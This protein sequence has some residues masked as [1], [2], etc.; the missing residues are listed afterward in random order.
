MPADVSS[1]GPPLYVSL[2][3][4]ATAHTS[5]HPYPVA[6]SCPATTPCLHLQTRV[7]RIAQAVAEEVERQHREENRHTREDT[8]PRVDLQDYQ[9]GFQVP[10][11]ARRGGLCP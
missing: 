11:P 8:D 1:Y 4:A 3:P 2:K 7:K 9:A 10:A 6:S 5:F